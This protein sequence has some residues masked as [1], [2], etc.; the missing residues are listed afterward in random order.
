MN[1]FGLKNW[2]DVY[3][4]LRDSKKQSNEGRLTKTRESSTLHHL[5]EFL[6]IHHAIAVNV[7]FHDHL[8]A[9][10]Q[11][12]PLVEAQGGE[13]GAELVHGD[14]AVAVLIEDVKGLQHV[15]LLVALLH[16]RLVELPELLHI[17]AAVA[18]DVDPLDHIRQLLLRNLYP[19]IHQRISELLHRYSA[20]AVP[21]EHLEHA[22]QLHRL[23][24]RYL[25]LEINLSIS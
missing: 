22:L 10:L 2:K 3:I 5:P 8:P 9:L 21:I 4:F 19:H 16:Y 12:P 13:H 24:Y 20:I 11:A 7:N 25:L 1:G 18:V 14:E 17:H 15:L 6:E 23:H